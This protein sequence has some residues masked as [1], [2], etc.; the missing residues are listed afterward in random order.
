MKKILSVIL[1][2]A[3]ALSL[4]ACGG[5]T[6]VTPDTVPTV[7]D[8]TESTE[9][10]WET[11]PENREMT[12]KQYFVYD[13]DTKEFLAEARNG[14]DVIYPAS[15]T[16]LFTAYVAL[17]YLNPET[18]CTAGDELDGVYAGSS[19][20]EIQKGDTLTVEELVE[21]MLLPSGNDAAYI[22][23][24][25][26]GRVLAH[27]RGLSG[28]EAV[29]RFV[30]EM[31]TQAKYMGM[32][33]THFANPD[34]IHSD[35]HRTTFSDIAI[36]GTLAMEDPVIMRY[37]ATAKAEKT[38]SDGVKEWKN[39]NALI[40]PESPYYCPYCIGLK[41]GQTPS[42]GSCLLSA[43]SYHGKTYLIGVFGC[44]DVD[45]RFPDTLLLFQNA[46]K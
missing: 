24:A 44:P 9:P 32:A 31:N 29:S 35:D 16:K 45:D 13:C 7:T 46:I 28:T 12:A 1:L 36:M 19:V 23:A 25:N 38:L 15:I 41:T 22:L 27:N 11:V 14:T 26:A 37:A 17:Q 10:V 6:V 20:A 21:A 4:C 43:F 39:T 2:A 40:H 42:A 3:L 18:L 30:T 34:G 33:D 5:N 8:G